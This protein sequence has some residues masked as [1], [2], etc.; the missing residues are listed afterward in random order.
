MLSAVVPFLNEAENL[1][2]L[3][4]ALERTLPPLGLAW[5]LVLVDDGSR[6][7]SLAVAK[8][9]LQ[10]RPQLSATLISLSR[11][12]GKEAALTAGLE[13]AQGDVVVPLD[14]DLQDPPELIGPMLE[15]WRQGF[16]V[17]Y[18]V[19][20]R[21]AGDSRTKRL[22]AFGFYRL[23]GRLSSTAIP[24][25]TGD[26]RLMDRCVVEALGQLPERSRFMKGLFAWVGF[27]QTAITFDR[28]ARAKGQSGWNYWKLW[29]FA[30]DG[31]TSFS[32]VPLQVLSAGGLLI[33]C[34][35]LLYGAWMVLRTLVFGIDLPGY[36]SLMTAVLFL[37]GVQLL[38]LGV[39]GEYLGRVFEEVKHRPLYLVRERW[40]Q[41]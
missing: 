11:N 13:A 27:R 35:A 22:T 23:M 16:D 2:R 30:L 9:E 26:F 40:R 41:G 6:D 4:E 29:N 14:A 38:G 19:R 10:R 34:L 3:I 31:I 8:A 1:P 21:R 12:F 25:D 18:A 37:G 24:A 32:R 5:E 17:V 36:A 7:G 28:D 15:Q 33:A 39:L 20:R